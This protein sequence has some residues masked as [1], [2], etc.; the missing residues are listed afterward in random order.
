MGTAV[1]VTAPMINCVTFAFPFCMMTMP[2][3]M[4]SCLS[5][6]LLPGRMNMQVR[7]HCPIEIICINAIFYPVWC[8][9]HPDT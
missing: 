3:F 1:H 2:M 7:G 4:T 5:F 6:S 8:A 9:V